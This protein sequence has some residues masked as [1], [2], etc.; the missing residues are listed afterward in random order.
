M[1]VVSHSCCLEILFSVHFSKYA[2]YEFA[3]TQVS[4]SFRIFFVFDK[5]LGS[6]LFKFH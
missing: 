5:A 6:V 1:S 2:I 4:E 3:F